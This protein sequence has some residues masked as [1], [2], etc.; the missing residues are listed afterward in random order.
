MRKGR[1]K[2]FSDGFLGFNIECIN[3]VFAVQLMAA[4]KLNF[5]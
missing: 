5:R 4:K 1:L 2:K 3:R